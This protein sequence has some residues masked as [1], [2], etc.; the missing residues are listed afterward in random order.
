MSF[1]KELKAIKLVDGLLKYKQIQVYVP[2]SKLRLLLLKEEY[3]RSFVR[4][5]GEN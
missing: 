3:D 1:A 4:H 2:Q 5:R